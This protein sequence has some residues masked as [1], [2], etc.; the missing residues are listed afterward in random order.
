MFADDPRGSERSVW[1]GG[2]RGWDMT[3]L[4]LG[5]PLFIWKGEFTEMEIVLHL[6]LKR[7]LMLP[8]GSFHPAWPW[9]GLYPP[10]PH[11]PNH[12]LGKHC[13][14][15]GRLWG[16]SIWQTGSFEAVFF[17]T[18]FMRL[19]SSFFLKLILHNDFKSSAVDFI[20]AKKQGANFASQ[21]LWLR[22]LWDVLFLNVHSTA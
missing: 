20:P 5:A 17:L 21:G 6:K 4:Q 18:D 16:R 14:P 22:R 15:L 9:A 13:I 11:K 7:L 12:W 10:L 1:F 3:H 8:P 2:T 19:C